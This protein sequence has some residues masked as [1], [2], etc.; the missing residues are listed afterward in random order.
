MPVKNKR[1]FFISLFCNLNW[2]WNWNW[3]SNWNELREC[4]KFGG[5]LWILFRTYMGGEAHPVTT[6][7]NTQA[8]SD[9]LTLP[10]FIPTCYRCY[11]RKETFITLLRVDLSLKTS[12]WFSKFSRG[13][14][15]CWDPFGSVR[16]CWEA[17]RRIRNRLDVC[18]FFWFVGMFEVVFDCVGRHFAKEF[19]PGALFLWR[20][21]IFWG[22]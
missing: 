20:L 10:Q 4:Q 15:M 13:F 18:D 14:R 19:C 9:F 1:I 22:G 7:Q 12:C 6:I 3:D 11:K 2:N 21:S 8:P 17:F 16:T 5:G